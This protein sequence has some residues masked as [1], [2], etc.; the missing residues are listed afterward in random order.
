MMKKHG[1]RRF[2]SLLLAVM[3]VCALLPTAALAE[4][5]AA[6]KAEVAEEGKQGEVKQPE[7]GTPEEPKPDGGKQP[8]GGTPEEPKQDEV[9][10]PEDKE[11]VEV[12]TPANENTPAAPAGVSKSPAVA[13]AKKS[14][15]IT[16]KVHDRRTG[17]TYTVGSGTAGLND[18]LLF[19]YKIP[20]LATFVPGYTFGSISTVEGDWNL[21]LGLIDKKVGDKARWPYLKNNGYITYYV[22]RYTPATDTD[23]AHW[24]KNF[25]LTYNGNGENAAN[26]PAEQVYRTNKSNETTHSFTISST[27]PTRDGYIFKG[28]STTADGSVAHQ[29]DGSIAVT[30]STTLYAVWE[31]VNAPSKSDVVATGIQVKLDCTTEGVEHSDETFALTEAAITKIGDP[32]QGEHGYTCDVTISSASYVPQF[33]ERKG[34]VAHT[35]VKDEETISLIYADGRWNALAVDTGSPCVFFNVRCDIYTVTYT[36]GRGEM[37]FT[38]EVHNNLKIGD[39]TPPYNNSAAP[40]RD[41]YTFLGWSPKVAETV[42][43]SVTYTA[44]W[45][46][47]AERAIKDLLKHITVKCVS[48]V[49]SHT[50][51]TYDTDV[52]GYTAITTENTDGTFTSKITVEAQ[53]YVD[54]YN[55]DTDEN[56]V[57]VNKEDTTKAVT[58]KLDKDY[59]P[60][61]VATD[62]PLITFEVKCKDEVV[63]PEKPTL[64]QLPEIS[65]TLHCGT[66]PA[67]SDPTWSPLLENT[68][69][70]S[71]P[72]LK[73]DVYTCTL[74][75]KAEKY[76]GEYSGTM[77]RVGKHELDDDATK[78]IVLTW[79]GQ[80]WTAEKD[81]VTFKV[82]CKLYTVTYTDGVK[83]KVI[84][85]DELHKDLAY[86]SNTPK[87]TGGTPKRTGYTFTGW[88]PK[89]ADTV[90]GNVTYEAQWKSNSGKDNVPKTGD[91]E[92]VMILG[93]VLMFSFCGATAVCLNDR[94]RKQG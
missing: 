2:F 34:N 1:L 9:K 5:T 71:A 19:S 43:G 11:P 38:D 85:K 13:A 20:D 81:G 17:N 48:S 10:Q 68:Y 52:G 24:L 29:P 83:N 30:G 62:K 47:K 14:I 90:T 16:V 65:V 26:V 3:M 77:Y 69:E 78:D 27:V 66:T 42:S 41:G 51:K 40:A 6:S 18:A 21:D 8:E 4:D 56:H 57:L 55:K 86:G 59:K 31:K 60:V 54:R 35:A 93:S 44:Q 37:W 7:G 94:K 87:F 12:E 63:P 39:T 70:I 88:S 61:G 32:V 84:F 53:K 33:N 73:N 74:T 25:K 79:G 58:V 89:V 15:P 80:K 64:A 46:N 76:V 75:V 23:D 45:E 67:H 49:E 82:K 28:W 91:G 50:T 22:D 36:D 92:T 72:T